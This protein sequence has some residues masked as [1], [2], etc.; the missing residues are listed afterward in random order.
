MVHPKLPD[1][2]LVKRARPGQPAVS[3]TCP[4]V[5]SGGT[6]AGACMISLAMQVSIRLCYA[7]ASLFH[8]PGLHTDVAMVVRC[9]N[10]CQ[11]HALVLS[12]APPLH[13]PEV[14]GPFDQ[15]H[16]DFCGPFDTPFVD[17]HSR[18]TWP[19]RPLK[20]LNAWVLW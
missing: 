10:N 7:C 16:I 15:V 1:L 3:R 17:S 11:R 5:D 19:E 4:L 6:E 14:L 12:Q 18:I 9:C 2:L 20:P 13:E 8:W